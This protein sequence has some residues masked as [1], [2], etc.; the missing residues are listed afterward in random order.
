[1]RIIHALVIMSFL[2]L[3]SS[4]KLNADNETA[5]YFGSQEYLK[6]LYNLGVYWDRKVLNLQE[7]CT[8]QYIIY[9]ISFSILKPLKFSSTQP[10]PTDG[11]WTYRYKFTRCGESIIY[12]ALNIARNNQTPQLV[13][14]V[15][16]ETNCSPTLI[17]DTYN[18]IYANLAQHNAQNKVTCKTAQVLNTEVTISQ[19]NQN[20]AWEEKWTVKECDR[21]VETSF[22]FTPS[23]KGGTNWTIGKCSH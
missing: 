8:S 14:L 11:I 9:P 15:P 21:T 17:K 2:V 16:G 7:T 10:D 5:K 19:K 18:G 20:S 12:N 4:T 22:C 23:E 1:M 13:Q 3:T 6:Q